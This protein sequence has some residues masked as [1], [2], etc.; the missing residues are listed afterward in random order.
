[1]ALLHQDSCAMHHSSMRPCMI[2][3]GIKVAIFVHIQWHSKR[4]LFDKRHVYLLA[5][6]NSESCSLKAA[7][8]TRGSLGFDE[9]LRSTKPSFPIAAV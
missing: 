5:A 7:L 8:Q 6:G 3:R 4:A 1:M 2:V 9:D